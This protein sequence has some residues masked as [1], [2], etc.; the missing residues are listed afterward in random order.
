M[1]NG[2]DEIK[3][4]PSQLMLINTNQISTDLETLRAT[5]PL[6]FGIP[7]I[8]CSI[9]TSMQDRI[10]WDIFD[11][12]VKPISKIDLLRAIANIG[13]GM[14]TVLVIDDDPDTRRLLKRMIMQKDKDIAV[15]TA[16]NGV[17]GLQAM[18]RHKVDVILLDLVMPRMDGYQFLEAKKKVQEHKD[19]PVI[20]ISGHQLQERPIVS[21][22][23]GIVLRGGITIKQFLQCLSALSAALG[24]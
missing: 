5:Q 7:A 3:R 21:D 4:S 18:Q 22:G 1:T 15:V 24:S 10:K 19:I 6:P 11:I 13:P 2:I 14:K 16:S 8:L 23:L 17:H 20:L 9:P 12:L